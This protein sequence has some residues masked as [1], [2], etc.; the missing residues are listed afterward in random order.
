M[1]LYFVASI[2]VIFRDNFHFT[3]ISK[4]NLNVCMTLCD[5]SILLITCPKYKK[6]DTRVEMKVVFELTEPFVA[7]SAAALR[8]SRCHPTEGAP[9]SVHGGMRR[10]ERWIIYTDTGCGVE[11]QDNLLDA[12]SCQLYFRWSRPWSSNPPALVVVTYC[13]SSLS[14]SKD[15]VPCRHQPSRGAAAVRPDPI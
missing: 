12:G 10:P 1:N 5:Q 2:H 14:S 7:G 6:A 11:K 9:S 13:P 8:G 3:Q 4:T 15:K